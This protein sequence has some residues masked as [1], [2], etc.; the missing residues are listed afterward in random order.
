MDTDGF[1]VLSIVNNATMNRGM[2]IS[3][4]DPVFISFGYTLRSGISGSY[5]SYF[6]K[7]FEVPLYYL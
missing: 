4:R 1:H 5:A 3:L 2:Q 6:L 7:I